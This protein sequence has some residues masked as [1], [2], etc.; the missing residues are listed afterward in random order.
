MVGVLCA[1]LVLSACGRQANAETSTTGGARGASTVIATAF[2]GTGVV[3][4]QPRT[5]G[6]GKVGASGRGIAG[7]PTNPQIT[8]RQGG[9]RTVFTVKLTSRTRL[10]AQGVFAAMYRVEGAGPSRTGCDRA[11]GVTIGRGSAG[12]R[13][14]AVLRPRPPGWCR[15]DWRGSV[16][17]ETG[18]N[19][20]RGSGAAKTRVCPEFA[21]RL[22][23]VGRFAWRVR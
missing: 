18:P 11:V 21:S 2:T 7:Q 14:A 23:E 6:T 19:C 10:G 20:A 5:T 16:L 1:A 22:V 13:L 4:S 17:L 12:R 8:P 9:P 3:S 15:G